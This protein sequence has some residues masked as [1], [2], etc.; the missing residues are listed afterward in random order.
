LRAYFAR[1]LVVGLNLDLRAR[2]LELRSGRRPRRASVCRVRR[3]IRSQ[4]VGP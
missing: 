3:L 4:R 1:R 2:Q